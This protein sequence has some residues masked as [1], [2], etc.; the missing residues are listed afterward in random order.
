MRKEKEGRGGGGERKKEGGKKRGCEKVGA[1]RKNI[2]VGH[3]IKLN[4]KTAFHRNRYV[5]C[6]T[7]N[8]SNQGGCIGLK[9]YSGSLPPGFPQK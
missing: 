4:S 8:Q 3:K 2:P 6:S 7:K 9:N 5:F 1:P